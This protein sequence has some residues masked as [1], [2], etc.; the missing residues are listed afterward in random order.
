MTE[1]LNSPP[2]HAIALI[3]VELDNTW[4]SDDERGMEG[5][6]LEPISTSDENDL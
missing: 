5:D 2:N 1:E 3:N 6:E 4:E